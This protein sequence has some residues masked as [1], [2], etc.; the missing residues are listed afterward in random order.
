MCAVS[1]R[2][3]TSYAPAAP[4]TCHDDPSC[5]AL[6]LDESLLQFYPQWRSGVVFGPWSDNDNDNDSDTLRE[7]QHLS[8]EGLALQARVYG[9]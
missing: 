7:V 9:S 5:K 8:D 4:P 6:H 2:L 3:V 1:N